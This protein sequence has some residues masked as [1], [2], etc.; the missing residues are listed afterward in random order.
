[1]L[2]S[3]R[4]RGEPGW[5]ARPSGRGPLLARWAAA[6]G[7]ATVL[8][9]PLIVAGWAQRQQIDWIRPAGVA[10]ALTVRLLIG[11]EP[12]TVTTLLITACAVAAAAARPGCAWWL[13]QGR[14]IR[15]AFP[16]RSFGAPSSRRRRSPGK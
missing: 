12:L 11:P 2:A 14:W 10:G 15:A 3:R 16:P 6:A 1:M 4:R 8:V 13:A 7:T 9:S 5:A